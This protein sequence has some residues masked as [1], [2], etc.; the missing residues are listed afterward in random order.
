MINR[1]FQIISLILLISDV[2]RLTLQ[3]HVRDHV[4]QY[5]QPRDH[6]HDLRLSVC[7]HRLRRPRRTSWVMEEQR[8]SVKPAWQTE[9]LEEE[10]IDVEEDEPSELQANAS[11]LAHTTSDLSFTQIHGL[12]LNESI[13]GEHSHT[14]SVSHAGTVLVKEDVAPAPFLPHTPGNAKKMLEKTFFSPLALERMFEPP[15]PPAREL[16]VPPPTAHKN[17]PAIPSRLSRMYVPSVDNSSDSLDGLGEADME[18]SMLWRAEQVGVE[19]D[20]TNQDTTDYEFTF[21]APDLDAPPSL[22]PTAN[23]LATPQPSRMNLFTPP[24]YSF[25]P[26]TDPR[27][28]LFQFQYDTFTRDHLSAM[29]DSIAVNTPAGGSGTVNSKDSSPA[30]PHSPSDTSISRL[31]SAKRLKLSPAS[32][33]SGDG[34]AFIMR[35]QSRIDYVG[36]S[37][38][39]MNKIRQARDFSTVSTNLSALTPMSMETQPAHSRVDLQIEETRST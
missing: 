12:I 32:D 35:P 6:H 5:V 28:R 14:S 11:A 23:Y 2:Q 31:R 1:I 26:P 34:D 22:L 8:S 19:E 4:Q 17:A 36:E 13:T 39:L 20:R 18:E 27:L 3:A 21:A 33:F 30:V 29:V 16:A 25:A 10:W 7:P 38:S 24:R 15:S 37:R 9:E